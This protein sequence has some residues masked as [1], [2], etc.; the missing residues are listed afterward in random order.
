ML[1]TSFCHGYLDK[2][3][4]LPGTKIPCIVKLDEHNLSVQEIINLDFPRIQEDFKLL[5]LPIVGFQPLPGSELDKKRLPRFGVMGLARSTDS[6]YAATWNG[7]YR[8]N[9]PNL[10]V[11]SFIT[12]TMINDP[13]G[14]AVC[15]DD[16][17]TVA[18]SLDTVVITNKIQVK[19]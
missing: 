13:H 8:L 15:G 5:K 18:T 4:S 6:L 17:Y 11:T 19:S 10:D 14:I 16:I 12:N 9:L 7:I 3:L 2:S 1:F